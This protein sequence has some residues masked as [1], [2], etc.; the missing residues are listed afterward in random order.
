MWSFKLSSLLAAVATIPF[1]STATPLA[2]RNV[3]SRRG[4][5]IA[6]KFVIVSMFE[7]EAAVWWGIDEF[8][9]LA[10]NITLPGLSPLFPEV[11]CTADGEICQVITGESEINAAS[12]MSAF[13]LSPKFDLTKSYFMVAGIGEYLFPGRARG[14]CA[15]FIVM[16]TC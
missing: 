3:V 12:T 11:H 9:L 2:E 8:D 7:P 5:V 13:V 15:S 14:S 6:P 10:Q 4:G 16:R 1:L